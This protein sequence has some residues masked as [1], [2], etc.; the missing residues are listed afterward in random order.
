MPGMVAP[1]NFPIRDPRSP[2]QVQGRIVNPVRYQ[3]KMGGMTGASA[4]E[5][6]LSRPNNMVVEKPTNVRAAK[7]AYGKFADADASNM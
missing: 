4:W 2:E 1:E 3:A 5:G 7:K 6:G